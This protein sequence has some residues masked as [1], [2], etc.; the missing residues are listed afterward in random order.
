MTFLIILYYI[1]Y[2]FPELLQNTKSENILRYFTTLAVLDEITLF[3]SLLNFW[4]VLYGF[5]W[6]LIGHND[7]CLGRF[8]ETSVKIQGFAEPTDTFQMV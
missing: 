3:K 8:K 7:A 2:I 6:L 1:Y 5:V 4:A